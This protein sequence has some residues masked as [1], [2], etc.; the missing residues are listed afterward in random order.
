MLDVAGL[1]LLVARGDVVD[2]LA[3]RAAAGAVE[4]LE[5]GLQLRQVGEARHDGL[6]A[7]HGERAQEEGIA[8]IGHRDHHALVGLAKGQR[9]RLAQETVRDLLLEDG[10]LR[11]FRRRG[12][13]YPEPLGEGVGEVPPGDEAQAPED[14]AELLAAALAL[15][16]PERALEVLRVELSPGDEDLAQATGLALD[17]KRGHGGKIIADGSL[18]PSMSRAG[19]GGSRPQAGGRAANTASSC[20]SQEDG[21]NPKARANR[22]QSRT[23]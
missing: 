10:K 14:H 2:D 5:G 6:A 23:E 7:H 13:G 21:A 18:R 1:L 19:A 8:G 9:P 4:P 16:Q 11:V 20:D 17:G 3:H 12:D 22:E 15:L